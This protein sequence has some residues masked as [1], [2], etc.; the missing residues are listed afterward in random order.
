MDCV[1]FHFVAATELARIAINLIHVLDPHR[2]V[3]RTTPA[4]SRNRIVQTG[5]HICIRC[6]A[7]GQQPRN[8]TFGG[9]EGA[10][11]GVGGSS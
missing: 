10:R 9:S 11:V 4:V 6:K 8:I 3:R 7:S 2:A 5:W 1:G